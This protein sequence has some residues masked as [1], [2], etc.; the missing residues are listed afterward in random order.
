MNNEGEWV[1]VQ[2]ADPMEFMLTTFHWAQMDFC[3]R[4]LAGSRNLRAQVINDY[5]DDEKMLRMI[6]ER[7]YADPHIRLTTEADLNKRADECSSTR[8][9]FMDTSLTEQQVQQLK[10]VT[11]PEG[12]SL[13]DLIRSSTPWLN[14]CAISS[15]IESCYRNGWKSQQCL[16]SS[17]FCLKG[18]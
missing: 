3:T 18:A 10:S 8:Q 9:R 15:V 11:L 7:L 6:F 14:G 13:L 16:A 5:K 2:V 1:H 12:I 17:V 4:H